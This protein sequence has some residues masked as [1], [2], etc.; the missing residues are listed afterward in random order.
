MKRVVSICPYCGCGCKLNYVLDKNKIIKI[1]LVK[2]DYISNGKPCVKGLMVHEVVNKN[3]ILYPMIR[4]NNKLKKTTWKIALKR[5]IDNTKNLAPE[6]ILFT[7]SGKIP[8]EDNYVIQKFARICFQTNNID[9][10][11]TRLCHAATV[12]GMMDCFGNANLT[13]MENINNIDTL[14]IIG[15]N[16]ENNYPVFFDKILKNKSKL[17]LI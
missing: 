1:E 4:V 9:S 13:K 16:P 7:A 15:S 6:E 2:D 11:C 17:K 12:A 3:R 14:L 5:I 10:C 8:N